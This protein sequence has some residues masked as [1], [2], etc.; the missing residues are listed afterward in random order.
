MTNIRGLWDGDPNE[1]RCELP[2]IRFC[3]RSA[4]AQSEV[5]GGTLSLPLESWEDKIWTF[6]QWIMCLDPRNR[7]TRNDMEHC[8]NFEVH[9]TY[10]RTGNDTLTFSIHI[11]CLKFILPCG[12]RLWY[13]CSRSRGSKNRKVKTN[14]QLRVQR[15]IICGYAYMRG[16]GVG[17]EGDHNAIE[18]A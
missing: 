6:C 16:T 9:S 12:R 11:V 18:W 17:Y 10:M 13:N 4:P 3:V 5:G 1:T 2:T 8:L 7:L 14:S 15:T